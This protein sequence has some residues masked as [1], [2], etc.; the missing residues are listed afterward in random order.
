MAGD[1]RRYRGRS[2]LVQLDEHTLTGVLVRE[3]STAV[4]LRSCSLLSDAGAVTTVDGEVVI[5]RLRILWLQV[6]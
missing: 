5:E 3:T 2:V 1:F 6:A 4:T